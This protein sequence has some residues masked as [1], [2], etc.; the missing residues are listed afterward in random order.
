VV[1]VGEA[2]TAAEEA[3]ADGTNQVSARASWP[4]ALRW[5]DFLPPGSAPSY[6][7]APGILHPGRQ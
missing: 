1:V 3:A 7:G 5:P 4:A 6:T 2:A